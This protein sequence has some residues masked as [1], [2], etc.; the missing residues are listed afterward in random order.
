MSPVR[1]HKYAST[2][3]LQYISL[4]GAFK[5]GRR[6]FVRGDECG[7]K[8][9]KFFCICLSEKRHSLAIDRYTK[10]IPCDLDITA[11]EREVVL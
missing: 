3:E 6:L 7:D 11:I 8:N 2:C 1:F 10:V 9:N 5:L 4:G